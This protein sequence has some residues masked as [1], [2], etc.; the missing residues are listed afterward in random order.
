MFLSYFV[1]TFPSTTPRSFFRNLQFQKK[2]KKEKEISNFNFY[3]IASDSFEIYS[4]LCGFI[5]FGIFKL[6]MNIILS[7]SRVVHSQS[8]EVTDKGIVYV[9]V[10]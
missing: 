4:C 5:L 7:V 9:V 10:D 8:P 6:Q 3:F 2:K 1:H